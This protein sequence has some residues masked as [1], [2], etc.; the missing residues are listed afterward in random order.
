MTIIEDVV[1]LVSVS[2]SVPMIN[3]GTIV[4]SLEAKKVRLLGRWLWE[5]NGGTDGLEYLR[6]ATSIISLLEEVE[7]SY[8]CE[9]EEL[10]SQTHC[11]EKYET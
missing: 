6:Q 8:Y 11:T 5:R 10:N 3:G 7:Q 4:E 1:G 2:Y 9:L